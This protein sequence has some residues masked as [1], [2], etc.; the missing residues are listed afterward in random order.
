MSKGQIS[1]YIWIIDTIQRYGRMT[2]DELNRLWLKSNVSDGKPL[3]RRTF[4][5]YRE[6][7]SDTFDISINYDSSTFEYYIEGDGDNN[8]NSLR[9]W[10]IDSASLS[11]M[12]SNSQEIASRIVLEYVP[13]AREHLPTIIEAIKRGVR[14]RFSHRAFNRVG[15]STNLIVE[16]YFVRI[17]KQ[18]WYLIG[19]N[20]KDNIIKTYGLDRIEELTILPDEFKFPE[21]LD[22]NSFFKDCFGI[23]HTRG[24]AKEI[25]IRTNNSQ[26]KYLRA[27]PLH[28]SQSETVHDNY[29]LF[30]YKLLITYD[31]VQELLSHGSNIEV[32]SP[33]ELKA[34]IIE[35]LQKSLA[36]YQSQ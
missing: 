13:S 29:S 30:Y 28:A 19:R 7:I 10:L 25:I 27:L 24:E 16:P 32:L 6:G 9:N 26:A 35:E 17:F 8:N 5:S 34:T 4:Y 36:Q 11:G 1:K 23:I 33:P 3:P 12:L 2:R 22:A 20:V 31:F 18:R 14:I 21:G 15:V